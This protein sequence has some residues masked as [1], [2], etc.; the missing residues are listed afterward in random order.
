[1]KKLLILI[2]MLLL[3][4]T[5]SIANSEPF[6]LT[7]NPSCNDA[8]DCPSEGHWGVDWTDTTGTYIARYGCVNNI[9]EII[10]RSKIECTTSAVCKNAGV[11]DTNPNSPTA[12]TCVGSYGPV[13]TPPSLPG[14]TNGEVAHDNEYLTLGGV[15]FILVSLAVIILIKQKFKVKK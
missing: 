8:S 6:K 11:C 15:V 4:I 9:C 10:N 3:F 5:F 7:A 13:I 14:G 2:T 12:W 1:M